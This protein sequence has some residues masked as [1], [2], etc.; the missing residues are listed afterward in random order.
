MVV[1]ETELPEDEEEMPLL[2]N[3]ARK[4]K[5]IYEWVDRSPQDCLN[6]LVSFCNT[7]ICNMDN[8]SKACVTDAAHTLGDVC[9]FQISSNSHKE[10]QLN[11]MQNN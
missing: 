9:T 3:N 4:K 1:G 8:R 6:E 10:N 7:L 2:G 5:N 11:F